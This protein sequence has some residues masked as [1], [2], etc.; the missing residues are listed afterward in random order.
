MVRSES[1]PFGGTEQSRKLT[2]HLFVWGSIPPLSAK[3]YIQIMKFKN[4][5]NADFSSMCVNEFLDNV[6]DHKGYIHHYYDVLCEYFGEIPLDIQNKFKD[7][8]S[9]CYIMENLK[10]HDSGML[11]RKIQ[12]RFP[13]FEIDDI[14]STNSTIKYI[15]LFISYKG[16]TRDNVYSFVNSKEL[17]N[18]LDFFG[19]TKSKLI[20]DRHVMGNVGT[21][22]DIEPLQTEYA[23]LDYIHKV[24]YD[25]LYHI[26]DARNVESIDRVGLRTRKG[27]DYREYLER[28]YLFSAP[29]KGKFNVHRPEFKEAAIY[30]TDS[31]NVAVYEISR[32]WKNLYRDVTSEESGIDVNCYFTYESIPSVFMRKVWQGLKENLLYGI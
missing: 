18:L 5:K 32:I 10:T 14:S 1:V 4:T 17:L 26:T 28:I 19:Y 8:P 16:T 11:V 6:V 20:E 27:N 9:D 7:N 12:E 25:K 13:E 3:L 24:C 29:P 22:L 21:E 31:E 15:R 2:M 23:D 30:F